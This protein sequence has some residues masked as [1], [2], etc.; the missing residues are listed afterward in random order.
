L[1]SLYCIACAELVQWTRAAQLK[2][3]SQVLTG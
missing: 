1:T 2:R 3:I